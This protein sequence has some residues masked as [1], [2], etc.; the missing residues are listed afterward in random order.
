MIGRN[1]HLAGAAAIVVAVLGISATNSQAA[2]ASVTYTIPSAL[3]SLCLDDSLASGVRALSCDGLNDQ[4]FTFPL[5]QP[6]GS[7]EIKNVQTGQCLKDSVTS[8]LGSDACT[9]SA[10]QLWQTPY[11]RSYLYQIQNVKTG[12]CID[13]SPTNG[14]RMV[15]CGYGPPTSQQWIL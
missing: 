14:L 2:Q 7:T 4:K 10:N 15:A 3:T 8:G 5:P 6:D 11:F 9:G 13:D 12:R 1:R